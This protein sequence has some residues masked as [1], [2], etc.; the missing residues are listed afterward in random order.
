METLGEQVSEVIIKKLR[1]GLN[2]YSRLEEGN[3]I[4]KDEFKK[5]HSQIQKMN[6]DFEVIKIW[7]LNDN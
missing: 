7:H 6:Q 1:D 4:V 2:D 3:K 5:L